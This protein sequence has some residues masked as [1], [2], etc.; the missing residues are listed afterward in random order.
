MDRHFLEFWGNFMLN[1][2]RSQ[3]QLEE[4]TEWV[5]K[6]FTGFEELTSLFRK[7]Y[8]LEGSADSVS[9]W[10]KAQEDFMKSMKDYLNL[11]GVVPLEEHIALVKKY[12]DLKEKVA[13][14]EETI[15]HLKMLLSESQGAHTAEV[16]QHFDEL[17]RKQSDQFQNLMEG[18]N[19]LFQKEQTSQESTSDRSRQV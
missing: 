18:F 2:S 3:K 19:R 9:A 7:I 17:I 14:Q 6:G 10:K 11:L 5:H 4:L 1:A 15:R 16:T 8:G 13:S 12:E